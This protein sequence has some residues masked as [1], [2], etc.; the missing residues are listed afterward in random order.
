M[1]IVVMGIVAMG[2]VFMCVSFQS[3]VSCMRHIQW[4]AETSCWSCA[5]FF[6]FCQ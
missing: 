1:G 5:V 4:C 3:F 6:Y 2:I